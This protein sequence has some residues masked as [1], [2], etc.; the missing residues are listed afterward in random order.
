MPCGDGQHEDPAN[1][2]ILD[3]NQDG[4]INLSDVVTVL[5]YLFVEGDNEFLG[6]GCVTVPGCPTACQ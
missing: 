3:S 1:V 4:T 6:S 5:T 2:A